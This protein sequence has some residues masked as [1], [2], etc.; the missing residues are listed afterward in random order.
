MYFTYLSTADSRTFAKSSTQNLILHLTHAT[1]LLK[2][3][4]EMTLSY[5]NLIV[6]NI[7]INYDFL[8]AS[9]HRRPIVA[10]GII[11]TFPIIGRVEKL[12]ENLALKFVTF[13]SEPVSRFRS[14]FIL[15][16]IE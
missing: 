4:V 6:K 13:T 8:I 10:F 1:L 15:C 2:S 5:W 14:S 11:W 9:Q 12:G 3:S 7:R 16:V